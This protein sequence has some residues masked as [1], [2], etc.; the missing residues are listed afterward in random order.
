M[1]SNIKRILSGRWFP[2]ALMVFAA[3]LIALGGYRSEVR[4]VLQKAIRI[5]LE[6]I[7]IG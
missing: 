3:G 1:Q 4:T 5:C 7:G 2:I 6:C